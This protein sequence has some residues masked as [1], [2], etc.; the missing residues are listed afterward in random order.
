M[1]PVA[2]GDLRI[3]AGRLAERLEA[4]SEIGAIVGEAGER[5]SARLALTDED[6]LG[7]ELVVTWM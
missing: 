7:R 6:R 5:G 2:P 3:D 4:L 1:K